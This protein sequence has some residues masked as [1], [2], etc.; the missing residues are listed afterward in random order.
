MAKHGRTNN[1]SSPCRG[2]AIASWLRCKPFTNRAA[3]GWR[4]RPYPPGTS[5]SIAI[6]PL[7]IIGADQAIHYLGAGIAD[8]IIAVLSKT[9]SLLVRPTTAILHYGTH[10]QDPMQAG[11]ALKVEA[12]LDGTLQQNGDHLRISLQLIKVNSGATLWAAPI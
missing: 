1:S 9:S 6:L 11:R 5:A 8:A 2:A 7:K 10:G 12:V 4:P 3:R